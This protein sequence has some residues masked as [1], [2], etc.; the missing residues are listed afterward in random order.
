MLHPHRPTSASGPDQS[1]ASHRFPRAAERPNQKSTTKT[2][3]HEDLPDQ[4]FLRDFVPSWSMQSRSDSMKTLSFVCKLAIIAALTLP[5]A[6][7]AADEAKPAVKP[8]DILENMRFR[9]L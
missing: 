7:L 2:R 9:N 8:K 3:R 5:L 6:A 1:C 4:P